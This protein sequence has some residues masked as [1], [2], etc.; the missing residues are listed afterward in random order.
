[1]KTRF[2]SLLILAVSISLLAGLN[3]IEPAGAAEERAKQARSRQDLIV[4][5]QYAGAWRVEVQGNYAYVLTDSRLQIGYF[6]IFPQDGIF[7][8]SLSSTN[9][10][11]SQNKQTF[12]L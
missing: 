5:G 10:S 1:M 11:I 3:R 9:D 4:I 7:Q 2:V 8:K 6:C 12:L